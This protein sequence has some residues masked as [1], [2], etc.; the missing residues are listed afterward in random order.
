MA[1]QTQEIS[2]DTAR[3]E[4]VSAKGANPNDLHR[5]IISKASGDIY[6]GGPDV[7]TADGFLVAAGD[8]L[9]LPLS[10]G[11]AVWGVSDL[12]QTARMLV[13]RT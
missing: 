4:I 12:P 1:I 3:T 6:V 13:T 10:L 2:L 8:V 5:L 11:D 7:T 9:E